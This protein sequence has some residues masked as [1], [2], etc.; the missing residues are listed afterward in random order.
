MQR[1]QENIVADDT[2]VYIQPSR[3]PDGSLRKPIRVKAG[4]VPQDEVPL[5]ESKGKQFAQ[6]QTTMTL[7]VGL[8]P[9]HAKK[10]V[11]PNNPIPGLVILD[12]D[13]KTKKKKKKPAAAASDSTGNNSS[14]SNNKAKPNKSKTPTPAPP[15]K[16]ELE[17]LAPEELEKRIKNLKK[18]VREI[19][20]LEAK[21]ESGEVKNPE[22]DQ[23]EKLLRKPDLLAEILAL[24][25][26]LHG[27]EGQPEEAD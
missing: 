9:S 21:I 3:R 26:V 14:S 25:L 18:K 5:Y 12:T 10:Q 1:L 23:K 6:R 27:D 2:G 4:Y 22:K 7:P 20:S 17:S 13:V 24:N 19:K 16:A 15:S 11:N 8:D